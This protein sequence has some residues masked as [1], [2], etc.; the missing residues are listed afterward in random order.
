MRVIDFF[1]SSAKPVDAFGGMGASAVAIGE[2]QGKARVSCVYIEPGGSIGAHPTGSGQLFLV[3]AGSGWVSGA[4][5]KRV[6]LSTGQGAL[7]ENGETHAKG[8]EAGMTALMI[9]VS[10]LQPARG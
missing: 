1:P 10:N 8:S 2:G 3:M 9:Q 7:F 5:G 6:D 4:D